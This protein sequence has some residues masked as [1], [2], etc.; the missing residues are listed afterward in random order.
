MTRENI[1]PLMISV[2]THNSD[3]IFQSLDLLLPQIQDKDV[4]VKIFDNASDPIYREK[5]RSYESPQIKIHFHQENKGFGYGHNHNI[6]NSRE[7]YGIIF[8]PDI[9][10]ESDVLNSLVN[11]LA[12]HPEC[13]MLAPKILNADG[14][15]QYLM[16]E[17]LNVFDYMLRFVPSKQLKKLFKKRLARFEC[18]DLPDDHDSYVR[19]IS[20]SFMVADLDKFREVGGFD[21]RF[22]MYFEDNDLCLTMEKAGYKLLYTPRF[23]VI[24]L[25]ERGAVKNKKLFK[26]FMS[27]MKKF[28]DKWGWHFF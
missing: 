5:L 1:R 16:R 14:S 10:I 12:E 19:M 2:V 9:L 24:H 25:Y 17:Y 22:F 6:F 26:I 15:T 8:N 20:G 13:S 3:K 21:E 7:R 11:L 18:R 4:L 23:S 28:F 27:S